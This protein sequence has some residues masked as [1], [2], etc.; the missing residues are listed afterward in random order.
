MVARRSGRRHATAVRRAR[1][2]ARPGEGRGKGSAFIYPTG[3]TARVFPQSVAAAPNK[4]SNCEG[5]RG[6]GSSNNGSPARVGGRAV[7]RVRRPVGPVELGNGECDPLPDA[8]PARCCLGGRAP[9]A[10]V[11]SR[12][13]PGVAAGAPPRASRSAEGAADAKDARGDLEP[14]DGGWWW[15]WCSDSERSGGRPSCSASASPRSSVRR[16]CSHGT[17][18][19][20]HSCTH[21]ART[22][23]PCC[24]SPSTGRLAA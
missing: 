15:W 21:S 18:V 10:V 6:N 24:A 14:N 20:G 4:T 7:F 17:A 2:K 11:R 19:H 1:F 22:A 8:L 9:P 13:L 12:E 5:P 3:R 23:A 16:Q